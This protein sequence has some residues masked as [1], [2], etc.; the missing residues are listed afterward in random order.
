MIRRTV[1]ERLQLLRSGAYREPCRH[2]TYR[3]RCNECLGLA[4]FHGPDRAPAPVAALPREVC[5]ERA[6]RAWR[7]RDY[8]TASAYRLLADIAR[9]SYGARGGLAD[10]ARA[11]DGELSTLDER[12]RALGRRH[13][14]ITGSNYYRV[15]AGER[16]RIAHGY[17]G[18]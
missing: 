6:H 1:G 16:R 2:A 14:A 11:L 7:A 4:P 5:S 18:M 3:T 13:A 17:R 12:R 8:G 9:A 10:Y 15:L